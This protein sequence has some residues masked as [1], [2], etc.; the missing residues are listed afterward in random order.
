[1]ASTPRILSLSP[2]AALLLALAVLSTG[3]CAELARRH[4]LTEA[5]AHI[6]RRRQDRGRPDDSGVVLVAGVWWVVDR[7][8]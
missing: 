5:W 4:H 8:A 7:S 3:I 6:P 2:V 1:M